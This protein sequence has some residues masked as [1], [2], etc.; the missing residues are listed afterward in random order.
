[1]FPQKF[2]CGTYQIQLDLS[3]YP[4]IKYVRVQW[5][6]SRWGRG[7][8]NPLFGFYVFAEEITEQIVSAQ[9]A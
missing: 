8:P 4:E 5:K 7:N 3:P 6:A 2:Y 9:S 1:L